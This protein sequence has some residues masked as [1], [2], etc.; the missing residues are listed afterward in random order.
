MTDTDA[1]DK[2]AIGQ[3]SV[4]SDQ[5]CFWEMLQKNYVMERRED[6]ILCRFFVK[7]SEDFSKSQELKSIGNSVGTEYKNFI[8]P[9]HI[10]N[11]WDFILSLAL[12]VIIS[13][14]MIW[15]FQAGPQMRFLEL[16]KEAL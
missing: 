2:D 4:E 16:V 13:L 15:S 14:I 10:M 9:T 11:T 8:L 5:F 7:Y 1:G 6:L 12:D 3:Y